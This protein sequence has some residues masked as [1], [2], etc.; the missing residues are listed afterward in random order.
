M[1]ERQ[2]SDKWTDA[3]R[4]ALEDLFA[5]ARADGKWFY[6][7]GLTGTYWFT[8]DELEA[9]QLKGKFL[10]ASPNWQ[11]RSPMERICQLNAEIQRAQD[12]HDQITRK[13]RKERQKATV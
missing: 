1:A 8:P 11:L 2:Y 10:W 6:F 12:E 5:T 3:D 9:E 13:I 4:K 7:G